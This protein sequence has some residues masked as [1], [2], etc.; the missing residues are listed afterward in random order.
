VSSTI[1]PCTDSD[2]I[3]SCLERSKTALVNA[4]LSGGA[5]RDKS[6]SLADIKKI[7]GLDEDDSEDEVY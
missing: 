5:Q 4:S 3:L 6:A 7:F 2:I 1:P